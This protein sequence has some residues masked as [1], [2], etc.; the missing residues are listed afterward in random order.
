MSDHPFPDLPGEWSTQVGEDY[1]SGSHVVRIR[2]DLGARKVAAYIPITAEMVADM[3]IGHRLW[4]DLTDRWFR[5]WRY[6][7]RNPMPT[8][9]LFPR[10]D[11]AI[12]WYHRRH[13]KH[14]RTER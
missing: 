14:R 1:L 10:L 2:Q 5:P 3:E 6:P 12:A 8:I 7:D 13:G 4:E 11:R 9:V